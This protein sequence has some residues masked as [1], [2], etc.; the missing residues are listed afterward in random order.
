VPF[1]CTRIHSKKDGSED[2]ATTIGEEEGRAGTCRTSGAL[3][4]IYRAP[5]AYTLG[6]LMAR[7][8][9]WDDAE[10]A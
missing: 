6:E 9:R 4:F 7:L 2:P 1:S 3:R 5:S 10:E 8:W